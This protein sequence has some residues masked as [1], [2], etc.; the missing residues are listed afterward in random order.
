M[1][2]IAADLGGALLRFSTERPGPEGP[3]GPVDPCWQCASSL[4]GRF[5]KVQILK[6]NGQIL[7]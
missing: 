1:E 4:L 7:W 6:L 2:S 5:M 3:E